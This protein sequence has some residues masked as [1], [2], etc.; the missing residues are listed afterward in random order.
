MINNK[1]TNYSIF[2]LLFAFCCQ[3]TNNGDAR[4]IDEYVPKN[5]PAV[6][7]I[8]KRRVESGP[9]IANAIRASITLRA[10]AIDL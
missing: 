1:Q 7:I 9:H 2:L 8:A 10:V 3:R 4:N 5:I 6:S